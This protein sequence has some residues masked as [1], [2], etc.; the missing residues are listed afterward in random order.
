MPGSEHRNDARMMHASLRFNRAS[1]G[2][3]PYVCSRLGGGLGLSNRASTG[4]LPRLHPFALAFLPPR[5]PVPLP[6]L[7]YVPV[8]LPICEPPTQRGCIVR[9]GQL[10]VRQ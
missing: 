5:T 8:P 7:S 6:L 10:A 2:P 3:L 1:T 4:P 9:M